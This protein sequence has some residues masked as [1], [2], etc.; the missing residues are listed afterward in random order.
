MRGQTGS[1][2]E[3]VG[4]QELIEVGIGIGSYVNIRC[5]RGN[6]LTMMIYITSVSV[7][8]TRNGAIT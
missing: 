6:I 4:F 5:Q 1:D 2:D 8:H 7:E 3:A